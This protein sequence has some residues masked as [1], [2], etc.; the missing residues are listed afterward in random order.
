M[1]S[2]AAVRAPSAFTTRRRLESRNGAPTA[3]R[4]GVTRS[5]RATG[6]CSCRAIRFTVRGELRPVINC[7][8]ER[9]K[10]I[11]GHFW[12]TTACRAEDLSIENDETLRWYEPAPGVRY[13]FCSTCGSSLF[14]RSDGT[15]DNVSVAAGSLD[16][17]SGLFTTAAWWVS[18][19]G[20]YHRLDPNIEWFEQEPT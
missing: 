5:P 7:H 1:A 13:G 9:C 2:M 3:Y 4:D 10:R 15:P 17:P 16:Q 19:A 6:A 12:A 8:C 20:D 14:W 11:S 18:N